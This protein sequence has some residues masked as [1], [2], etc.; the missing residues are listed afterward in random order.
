MQKRF[1]DLFWDAICMATDVLMFRNGVFLSFRESG[2]NWQQQ[3]MKK[4][5]NG[6]CKFPI[7]TFN[8][9][10]FESLLH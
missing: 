6:Y 5:K 8:K 1:F 10:T 9:I 4:K 3:M 7:A 2:L